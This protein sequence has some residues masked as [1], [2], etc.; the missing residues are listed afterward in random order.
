MHNISTGRVFPTL[1]DLEDTINVG[2]IH[3]G[4]LSPMDT[5]RVHGLVE[6][7]VG[8]GASAHKQGKLSGERR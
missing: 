3:G 1:L 5:G 7:I 8:I 2:S 4:G 6:G